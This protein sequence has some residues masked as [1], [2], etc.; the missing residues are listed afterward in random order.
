MGEELIHH[1][2]KILLCLHAA[3]ISLLMNS[4]T[5]VLRTRSQNQQ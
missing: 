1:I 3:N 5:M 2:T 4:L